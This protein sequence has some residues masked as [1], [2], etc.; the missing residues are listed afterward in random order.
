VEDASSPARPATARSA[1]FC[2]EGNHADFILEL[3]VNINT[4]NSGVQ[5]RSTCDGKTM[6]LSDRSG[7]LQTRLSGGLYEQGG[8]AGC[9]TCRNNPT[10]RAAFKVGEWNKYRIECV[11]DSIKSWVN[12]SRGRLSRLDGHQRRHRVA[13]SCGNRCLVRFRNIRLQDLADGTKP[14]S[15]G[16]RITPLDDRLASKS[17]ARFSPNTFLRTCPAFL[18]SANRPDNCR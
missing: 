18:L 13:G 8:A 10:A 9:K 5:I 6:V 14:G 15:S 16:V 17:T 7:P 1:G 3:E 2:T 4:G 12:A 11:G